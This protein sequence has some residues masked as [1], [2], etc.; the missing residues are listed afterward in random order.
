MASDTNMIVKCEL[1]K[2][3]F[4]HTLLRI[5][6]F[7]VYPMP[8]FICNSPNRTIIAMTMTANEDPI[9]IPAE[10]ALSFKNSFDCLSSLTGKVHPIMLQDI[11][12]TP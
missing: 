2:A 6:L 11:T 4:D 7:K 5:F 10:L 9:A 1:E 8:Y 3:I 12:A